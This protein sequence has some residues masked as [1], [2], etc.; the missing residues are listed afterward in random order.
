MGMVGAS[1]DGGSEE[2]GCRHGGG[3]EGGSEKAG[4][5][6]AAMDLREEGAGM[7]RG[8]RE[9]ARRQERRGWRRI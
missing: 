9:V 3:R 6:R 5:K 7:K 2:G 8:G 1:E 4:E